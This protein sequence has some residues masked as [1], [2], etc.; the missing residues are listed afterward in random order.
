MGT[1]LRKSQIYFPLFKNGGQIL[2]FSKNGYN[3]LK[4]HKKE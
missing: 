2:I 3:Q 4:D 1:N